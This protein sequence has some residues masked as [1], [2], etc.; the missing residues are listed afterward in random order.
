MDTQS[1]LT[2]QLEAYALLTYKEIEELTRLRLKVLNVKPTQ[3]N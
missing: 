2:E 1:T 3:D